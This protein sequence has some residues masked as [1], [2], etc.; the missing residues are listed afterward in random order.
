MKPSFFLRL[1]ILWVS[2]ELKSELYIILMQLAE[3]VQERKKQTL[4]EEKVAQYIRP[5][6]K[7]FEKFAISHA[8]IF[9]QGYEK[10]KRTSGAVPRQAVFV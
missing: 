9:S 5:V 7:R 3:T 6:T 2:D 4:F 8:C 10:I 1:F